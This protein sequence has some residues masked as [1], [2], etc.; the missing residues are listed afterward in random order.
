MDSE[1]FKECGN[2]VV[3][4]IANYMNT[5]RDRYKE[6]CD[7]D[8]VIIKNNC[9]YA[10]TFRA[11]LNIFQDFQKRFRPVLSTVQ[12][13]YLYKLVPPEA[14]IKG[15]DWQT[16]M[17]DVEKIIMPGMTHWNS[18]QFHAFF[19]TGNSFAA[20]IGDMVCNGLGCIGFS[21]VW[22]F[23]GSFRLLLASAVFS[24]IN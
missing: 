7:I 10:N 18:P 5:I 13:G 2:F 8:L 9:F 1:S 4:Y 22:R 23:F 6:C 19:P 12:P 3:N 15:E 20:I 11:K 21:W 14:P 24:Y 17:T 16:V